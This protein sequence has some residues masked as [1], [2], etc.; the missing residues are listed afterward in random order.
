LG[1]GGDGTTLLVF[2]NNSDTV[3]Q[4]VGLQQNSIFDCAQQLNMLPLTSSLPAFDRPIEATFSGTGSAALVLN[5]GPECGGKASSISILSTSTLQTQAAKAYTGQLGCGT[6]PPGLPISDPITATNIP[7]PG[8]VTK[9]FLVNNTLYVAGQ[10]LYPDGYYGGILTPIT[11]TTD[12]S[13]GIT[14]GTAGTGIVIGDGR[15][16]RMEV[17]DN[18]TLWIA[19]YNC[20]AGE[21]A[22]QHGKAAA[23]CITMYNMTTGAVM[24]TPSQGDAGG[25]APIVGYNETYTAEG[26][27]VYVYS[28]KDGSAIYNGNILIVGYVTDVAYID[29]TVN[30]GP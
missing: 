29:G 14:T 9:A 11:L 8:G 18:N 10:M 25:V 21:Y 16:F 17:G 1:G 28:T 4:L 24:V 15:H 7:V 12:P 26:G 6:N 22:Q 5:C 19:A 27:V 20:N 30:T 2:I 3:Y 23:G 13:T